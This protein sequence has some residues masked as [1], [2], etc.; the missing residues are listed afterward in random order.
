MYIHLISDIHHEFKTYTFRFTEL[1]KGID[2]CIL[3][4][5]IGNPYEET[6]V[7]FLRYSSSFFKNVILVPG[8]HEYYNSYN[9]YEVD[10]R[11]RHISNRTN[12][13]F[14]NEN[15]Y[16]L[17]DIKFIGCALWSEIPRKSKTLVE[18]TLKSRYN[19]IHN[20]NLMDVD[21]YNNLHMSHLNFIKK[22]LDSSYYRCVVVTHHSP[23]RN[24]IEQ[25]YYGSPL[26]NMYYS[27]CDRLFHSPLIM[28]TSG[29]TH[30]S[31]WIQINEID[32]ISNAVGYSEQIYND[33]LVIKI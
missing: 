12:V 6:Y 4:G 24:M 30:S 22:E 25:R 28:W 9:I 2:C 19:T 3:A 13:V 18:N 11:L 16:I 27:E 17:D 5:D 1:L 20:L 33:R 29:H 21:F 10:E 14:L 23:S 8:N 32:S 15:T 26:S 7:D 31:K